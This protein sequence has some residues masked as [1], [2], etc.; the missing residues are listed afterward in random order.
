[1]FP[2]APIYTSIYD[3]ARMPAHWR[4][5]DIRSSWMDRLPAVHRHHQ[6]VSR[7]GQEL[8]HRVYVEGIV[9]HPVGDAGE[10]GKVGIVV[11]KAENLT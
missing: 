2:A 4:D 6:M 10:E 3:R 9:E 8:P 7:V 11:Q 5:W 1:M